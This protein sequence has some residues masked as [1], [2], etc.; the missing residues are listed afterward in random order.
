MKKLLI[1]AGV[2]AG[3]FIA[4]IIILRTTKVIT[5]YTSTTTANLPSIQINETL[6]VSNLKKPER[7]D[8]V[9]VKCDM[10]ITGK[11]VGIY[12]LCGMEGDIIEIKNGDLILN[13]ESVDNRFDLENEYLLPDPVFAHFYD[14][15]PVEN[16]S[17]DSQGHSNQVMLSSR[18]AAR[19][20]LAAYKVVLDRN[21]I[22][23]NIRLHFPH[24]R[25][26]DHFGPVRVPSG[27]W[28]LLGDNRHH[29]AD[30]RYQGFIRKDQ[31]VATVL[32]K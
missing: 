29:A 5:A 24:C 11:Y 12:R 2:L 32:G 15:I 10:P 28:F 25:N 4:V 17:S 31:F 16:L 19:N 23:D 27:N 30:S 8:F 18:F 9:C 20:R 21:Y 13:G 7:F 26:A 1:I 22:D 14:S 6:F 3:L